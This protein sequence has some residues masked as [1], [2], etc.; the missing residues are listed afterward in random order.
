MQ[1]AK[2]DSNIEI[3]DETNLGKVLKG[4]PYETYNKKLKSF[5]YRF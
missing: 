1:N 2:M 4:E 3:I 5:M